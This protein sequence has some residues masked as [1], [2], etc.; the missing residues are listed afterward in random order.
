MAENLLS[1]DRYSFYK[2]FKEKDFKIEIPIIQRDYAQGRKTQTDVRSAFL[3]ALYKYLEEGK[4]NRDLDFVYGSIENGKFIP[5]DGQQRLTTL[6][7]L[8]WYLCQICENESLKQSFYE[9]M[10][11]K[12]SS[13]NE[14]KSKFTYET[15]RSSSEFCDSLMRFHLAKDK[16]SA[17]AKISDVIKDES[18][19]FRM[20]LLDPTVKSMLL[21]LDSIHLKFYG[22]GKF[23]AGL[24]NEDNPIITFLF[25]DL[26]KFKLSDDLYIKMNARGKPLSEFEN[27]KAKFEQYIETIQPEIDALHRQ[28]KLNG[29]DVSLKEYFSHK[30]DT[31]WAD[32]FWTYR[33]VITRSNSSEDNDFDDEFVNFIRFIFDCNYAGS[34]NIAIK[35]K[36]ATLEF[37]NT[38]NAVISFDNYYKM[39]V[40]SAKAVLYLI[41]AFDVLS[42]HGE[43]ITIYLAEYDSPYFDE[44]KQFID[45]LAGT[46]SNNAKL[47]MHAYLR[48]LIENKDRSGLFDWMRIICN[49]SHPDNTIID[50]SSEFS[51]S[52]RSVNSLLM[53]AP[54]ILK[55]FAETSSVEGFSSWQIEE[56]KIKAKLMLAS[57][58][59]RYSILNAEISNYPYFN[60][61][62][63]ILLE[64]AGL[65]SY[66]QEH[67]GSTWIAENIDPFRTI[68]DS[69]SKKIS[70]IFDRDYSQNHNKMNDTSCSFERAV[71][72]K[73][74]YL[75]YTDKEKRNLMNQSKGKDNIKRDHSWKRYLRCDGFDENL[76]A[77]H[78]YVKNVLDDV[79]LDMNDLVNSLNKIALKIDDSTKWRYCFIH[80]NDFWNYGYGWV[81]FEPNALYSF[82]GSK[83]SHSHR[84]VYT[85]YFWKKYL[86]T[87]SLNHV[88][89]K[90]YHESNRAE[91]L[92]R[93]DSIWKLENE[94]IILSI[95]GVRN[96]SRNEGL[97]DA[98]EIELYK[99]DDSAISDSVKQKLEDNKFNFFGNK[100]K[101]I[102]FCDKM[103]ETY[104]AIVECLNT[105][106]K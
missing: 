71:L 66:Y 49:L 73:G 3:D 82:K 97:C 80:L 42:E 4:P 26:K 67:A 93:I 19:F 21:M 34:I 92:P 94:K 39:N 103:T 57:D 81:L 16:M 22:K 31:K 9:I 37:L 29:K 90:T 99:A 84:E 5:L 88:L 55:Y 91:D 6:F 40:L 2:L 13:E 46:A 23:F 18:W 68:F 104:D 85:Y 63:G 48:Y 78:N 72:S 74:D 41:D 50:S 15:R 59:W 106:D 47:Q 100:G 53:K 33:N 70:K 64:F 17:D 105:L 45:I 38:G 25:M 65:R 27:F 36:D 56:E 30:I 77:H 8:H 10:T 7:L 95:T 76:I 28:F 1:N 14:T 62:I 20:W 58:E 83:R 11:V 61:Q 101:R 86:E 60:G 79:D 44:K 102:F 51:R 43:N 75:S 87:A 96:K 12:G 32:L 89:K 98:I 24:L 54:E 69:Y 52:I 35:D